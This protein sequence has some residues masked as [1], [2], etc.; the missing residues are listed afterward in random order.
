MSLN[1]IFNHYKDKI[2]GYSAFLIVFVVVI[3]TLHQSYSILSKHNK[4][5]AQIP[6]VK[7]YSAIATIC[8]IATRLIELFI[9]LKTTKTNKF[10]V[11]ILILSIFCA[12]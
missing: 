7:P 11:I 10:W 5:Y 4:F 1:I 8:L 3:I 9:V 12:I 2:F 6:I